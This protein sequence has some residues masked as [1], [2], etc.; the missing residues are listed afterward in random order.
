[1][2]EEL[3]V[4]VFCSSWTIVNVTI[5]GKRTGVLLINPLGSLFPHKYGHQ[6][7]IPGG[8]FC[9]AWLLS[10][11]QMLHTGDYKTMWEYKYAG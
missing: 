5:A 2:V 8:L 11:K 10:L 9:E 6:G 3:E 1:V 7:P 4:F